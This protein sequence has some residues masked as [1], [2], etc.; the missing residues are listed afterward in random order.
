M[1]VVRKRLWLWIAV[2]SM[3]QHRIL[4]S[5]LSHPAPVFFDHF[6]RL[7]NS[8]TWRVMFPFYP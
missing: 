2:G 5:R 3:G 4:R 6:L 8:L 7:K 1:P